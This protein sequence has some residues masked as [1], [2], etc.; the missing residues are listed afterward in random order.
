MLVERLPLL[1]MG[2][3]LGC[4][5]PIVHAPDVAV[6]PQVQSPGTRYSAI[7][8]SPDQSIIVTGQDGS[9]AVDVWQLQTGLL[10][11]SFAGHHGSVTSIRFIDA[12]TVLTAANDGTFCRFELDDNAPP[13]CSGGTFSGVASTAI[14]KDG[15]WVVMG[16]KHD[17]K[18]ISRNNV[19]VYSV[20][21]GRRRRKVRKHFGA[22][23]SAVAI[24]PDNALMVSVGSGRKFIGSKA[25]LEERR[26]QLRKL[27]GGGLVRHLDPTGRKLLRVEFSPDGRSLVG[28]DG[29]QLSVW[30]VDSGKVT[31]TAPGDAAF[32]FSSAGDRLYAGGQQG[33]VVYAFPSLEKVGS[34]PT[35][36]VNAVVPVDD[37]TV[38]TS[39]GRDVT[40]WDVARG[41]PQGALAASQSF[42]GARF[43]DDGRRAYLTTS[44][45]DWELDLQLLSLRRVDAVPPPVAPPYKWESGRHKSNFVVWERNTVTVTDK[46]TGK[47]IGTVGSPLPLTTVAF[48]DDGRHMLTGQ[49][50]FEGTLWWWDFSFA[51]QLWDLQT[52]K[53][54]RTLPAPPDG[55]GAAAISPDKRRAA[56]GGA[57]FKRPEE[58]R[59]SRGA[60]I[61]VVDL[62]S[63]KT[64]RELVGHT[65]KILTLDFSPSGEHLLS[66][67]ADGTVR[68]WHVASGASV[69]V[70]A[71][72]SEWL[73]YGDDGYFDAS[74]YGHDLVAAVHGRRAFGID[75]VAPRNNRPDVLLER[76][77]LGTPEV[78]EHF[79][80]R[81]ASRLRKLGLEES[82]LGASVQEAPTTEI[83]GV[84]VKGA[85]ARLDLKVADDRHDLLRYHVW[86]NGVPANG[87]NGQ[88]VTGR[89]AKQSVSVRLTSGRNKIEVSAVNVAGVESLRDFRVVE[90]D[91][92]A[93]GRL[94]YLGFG[95]SEYRDTRLNLSYAHQDALDL[96]NVLRTM[97]GGPFANV[98]T[99]ALVDAEVTVDNIKQAASFLA[100]ATVDDTVVLFVAGHGTHSNDAAAD[101]YYVTHET[102][103]ARLT[104]TAAKF[105]VI[106]E[107]LAN[108]KA[109]H[110]LLLLDTC[111]SGEREDDDPAVAGIPMAEQRGLK[112]RT[113]RAL[114]LDMGGTEAAPK[115]AAPAPR[116][117][118]LERERYIYNDL[119]R[120]TGAIVFASSRGSEFSYERSAL[121]NGV[122][123]EALVE[124]L[125]SPK[126]DDDKNGRVDTQELRKY[127]AKQVADMTDGK[128]NPTI[129]RDNRELEI[130]LPIGSV[131]IPPPAEPVEPAEEPAP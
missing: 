40:R 97:A 35:G 38:V 104:E 77:A 130:A 107:L 74:R 113:T 119:A 29:G 20:E 112:P 99:Q 32:A 82:K 126:A 63:G 60:S 49:S 46:R 56:I 51:A 128:Q 43:S 5:S 80:A 125:T 120:R 33:I 68:L 117:W 36:V 55:V 91:T 101:Y 105:D 121:Q 100:E 4:A 54:L 118:L 13:H 96:E 65:R 115:A 48:S 50:G 110:K 109:R 6:V 7:A 88:P 27:P 11:G 3:M 30:A 8:V 93:R 129:D 67:S 17:R 79:R 45:G 16:G 73:V 58:V 53:L 42:S 106:E 21:S 78:I 59:Y 83:E 103:V 39:A 89:S 94:F 66:A 1:F 87:P 31:A 24:S 12:T 127:V 92:P 81:Y 75:Q 86:V 14:S 123:T 52:G 71:A 26:M 23:V 41:T 124:A 9:G 34:V 102:D 116:R 22:E 2:V 18:M 70:V 131:P 122:F 37:A 57:D 84:E 69:A 108:T 15:T 76:L 44:G 61:Y 85:E 19:S 10:L 95:V 98:R 90:R 28:S 64:A 62:E 25:K 114:V 72:G 47:P 111:E